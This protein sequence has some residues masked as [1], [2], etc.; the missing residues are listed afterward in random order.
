MKPNSAKYVVN[1]R[2]WPG[3]GFDIAESLEDIMKHDKDHVHGV[4]TIVVHIEDYELLPSVHYAGK[5]IYV[6]R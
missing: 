3:F 4:N 6:R 5:A 1:I 2:P